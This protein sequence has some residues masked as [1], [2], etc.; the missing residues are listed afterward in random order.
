[1]PWGK[2]GKV[3]LLSP[4]SPSRTLL[5]HRPGQLVLVGLRGLV[6]LDLL[7]GK[8]GVGE[9]PALLLRLGSQLVPS[10]WRLELLAGAAIAV[11]LGKLA[12]DLLGVEPSV[13]AL[14][15]VGH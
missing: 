10:E 4:S 15:V 5:V 12:G 11:P 1:M 9:L 14:L 2:V 8:V 13:A 7:V 3:P 6:D